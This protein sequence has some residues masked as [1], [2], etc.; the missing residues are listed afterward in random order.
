LGKKTKGNG[1]VSNEVSEISDRIIAL[2][3]EITS[4]KTGTLAVDLQWQIQ[5]DSRN[6]HG[7]VERMIP[8]P[9]L[10]QVYSYIPT[11]RRQITQVILGN[12]GQ[13]N[14]L[15]SEYDSMAQLL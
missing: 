1:N 10:W 9:L 2:G 11:G 5:G 15:N 13:V 3:D 14:L 8:V 12:D 4:G 6:R 7:H